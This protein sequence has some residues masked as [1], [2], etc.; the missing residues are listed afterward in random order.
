[1]AKG[2][3][4]LILGLDDDRDI[5][6]GKRRRYCFRKGWYAYVG[7]ALSGLERRLRR[8]LSN[9]KSRHWNIDYLLE[10]TS[11]RNIIYAESGERK[12]CDVAQR[13]SQRLAVVEGFGCSDCR[14]CSHLFFCSERQMLE[15]TTI[16]AFMHL[17]LVPTDYNNMPTG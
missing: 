14:C 3:Y 4:V 11:I 8:H 17:C 13:L 1:L 5:T 10:G 15:N 12:E 2:V 16:A 6:V 7:S 9:T